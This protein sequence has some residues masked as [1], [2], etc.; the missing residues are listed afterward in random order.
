MATSSSGERTRL[1]NWRAGASVYSG[2][3]DPE[4]DVDQVL[5]KRLLEMWDQMKPWH[6]P[7]P[8]PPGLG[9]RGVV[10]RSSEGKR[11]SAYQGAVELAVGDTVLVRRDTGRDFERLILQSAPPNTLP[12][13]VAGAL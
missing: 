6:G 8:R 2:R 10:L 1:E 3:P 9:Y 5:V 7:P 4:W 11:F 12:P 13:F